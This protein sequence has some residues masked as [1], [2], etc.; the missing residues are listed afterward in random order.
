VIARP[1][2]FV[3]LLRHDVKLNFLRFR[4][5]FGDRG[6]WAA[7]GVAAAALAA[8]HLLC[9]PVAAWFVQSNAMAESARGYYPTLAFAALFV[10]PWLVSQALLNSTRA[11]YTRGDLD[12][13]LTSPMSARA[14]VSSRALAIAFE[15]VAS[16]GIFLFPIIDMNALLGGPRW[17]AAYPALMASGLLATA[18]GL[19]A[20]VVLFALVGPRRTRVVSQVAATFIASAFVLGGQLVNLTP[21]DT[22]DAIW[23]AIERPAPGS[24]MDPT[25]PL[26]LPVRAAMGEVPDLA[27]WVSV[28]ALAFVV[29]AVACGPA[30]M[31]S[32]VRSAGAA[33]VASQRKPVRRKGFRVGVAATLRRKEWRLLARDPWLFSQMLLQVV[34][35]LP[36]S[37]VIW[38]SPAIGGSVGLAVSPFLVVVASQISA[39]LAWLAMSSEDAPEFLL[40][41]PIARRQIERGKM[42]AVFLPLALLLAGPLLGLALLEWKTA[43]ATAVVAGL[44]A[45]TTA[46][47]NLWHPMPGKRSQLLRRHSQSKIVGLMEHGMAMCW[48]TTMALVLFG[49]SFALAPVFVVAALLWFVRPDKWRR[50]PRPRLAPAA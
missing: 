41:A 14:V 25:G 2:T 43:L 37:V 35:T 17:L 45:S 28:S 36:I 31:A 20:T 29:A 15:A 10:M 3:W 23:A 44:A 9:W 42:E 33:G 5:M 13:L 26:W 30:F 19:T 7:A 38:R 21:D 48:A 16:V 18:I 27:V 47:L 8:I 1:G 24:L 46:L 34:Y 40:T 11:L 49:T 4:S 22:R 39:S 50:A 6:P 32:A 12:L